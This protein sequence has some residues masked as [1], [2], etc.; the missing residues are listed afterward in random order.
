MYDCLLCQFWLSERQ[1]G[2]NP[3]VRGGIN[4]VV[5]SRQPFPFTCAAFLEDNLGTLR[6]P[7]MLSHQTPNRVENLKGILS[8]FTILL[9]TEKCTEC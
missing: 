8:L 4:S 5:F 7:S 3:W 2:L 6:I 1:P 9:S